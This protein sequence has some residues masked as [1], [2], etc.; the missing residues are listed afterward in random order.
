MPRSIS[1]PSH[2]YISTVLTN[3]PQLLT[4]NMTIK[5]CEYQLKFKERSCT[6]RKTKI[7][8]RTWFSNLNMDRK[9]TI[10]ITMMRLVYTF[11]K[12][13]LLKICIE[14]KPWRH[15]TA[16][17]RKIYPQKD[18]LHPKYENYIGSKQYYII[19]L[20]ICVRNC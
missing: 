11:C 12:S 10:T 14:I 19:V 20:G 1:F 16:N 2:R 5:Y 8:L 13:H 17:L 15:F 18:L 7:A 6:L 4:L 9:F 3:P